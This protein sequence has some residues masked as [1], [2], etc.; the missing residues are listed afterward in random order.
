[1]DKSLQQ[2]SVTTLKN[3]NS[4]KELEIKQLIKEIESIISLIQFAV[5][6]TQNEMPDQARNGL[7]YLF[8]SVIEKLKV[9]EKLK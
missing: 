2:G 4:K 7:D 9:V 8:E 5:T 6:T 1:M 3:D